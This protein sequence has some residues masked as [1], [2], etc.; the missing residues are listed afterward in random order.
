MIKEEVCPTRKIFWIELRVNKPIVEG[1]GTKQERERYG[2]RL[3]WPSFSRGPIIAAATADVA[4]D[5]HRNGN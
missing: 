2:E 5:K 3:D 4:D 1:G